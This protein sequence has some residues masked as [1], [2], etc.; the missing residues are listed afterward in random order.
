MTKRLHSSTDTTQRIAG[1]Y[2]RRQPAS[3]IAPDSDRTEAGQIADIVRRQ[4]A[5]GIVP[6][7]VDPEAAERMAARSERFRDGAEEVPDLWNAGWLGRRIV[8]AYRTLLALRITVGPKSYGSNWPAMI[9]EFHD[10][11]GQAATGEL[12]KGRNRVVRAAPI[13]EISRMD[14]VFELPGTVLKGAPEDCRIL[15]RWGAWRADNRDL[16]PLADEFGMTYRTWRRHRREAANRCAARLNE[17]SV[18]PF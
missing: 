8:G 9:F 13:D 3:P 7:Q 4:R 16:E 15:M 2:E 6:G 10:Q 11:V 1:T 14:K 12:T 18:R 5:L 17:A